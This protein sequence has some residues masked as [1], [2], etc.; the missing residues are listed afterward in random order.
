V[1]SMSKKLSRLRF[2]RVADNISQVCLV[3]DSELQTIKTVEKMKK[4]KNLNT[5]ETQALNIPVF[6]CR[7]KSNLNRWIENCEIAKGKM[8]EIGHHND[9]EHYEAQKIAYNEVKDFL[10]Q[11]GL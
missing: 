11:N 3:P 10:E 9:A 2:L 1:V 6:I 8:N 7:L 4:E 5:A